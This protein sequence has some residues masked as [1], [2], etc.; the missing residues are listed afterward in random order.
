MRKEYYEG[1][2]NE[3]RLTYGGSLEIVPSSENTKIVRCTWRDKSGNKKIEI[4]RF[5]GKELIGKTADAIRTIDNII[6]LQLEK[7]IDVSDEIKL[8]YRK[9]TRMKDFQMSIIGETIL[10]HTNRGNLELD[11]INNA[12]YRVDFSK[13]D[14]KDVLSRIPVVTKQASTDGKQASDII[15]DVENYIDFCKIAIDIGCLDTPDWKNIDARNKQ[16]RILGNRSYNIAGDVFYR[17]MPNPQKEKFDMMEQK[18]FTPEEKRKLRV[19]AL[20]KLREK[21]VSANYM[22]DTMETVIRENARKKITD[23]AVLLEGFIDM[24]KEAKPADVKKINLLNDM[25]TF[26]HISRLKESNLPEMVH[27]KE[28]ELYN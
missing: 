13:L 26:S 9:L 16:M 8:Q 7:N 23:Y 4:G 22:V 25:V 24:Y 2:E 21:N 14:T 10:S 20:R 1:T 12:T 19:E 6:S 17:R 27:D 3:N 11:D 18:Y 5:S 28:P 15:N